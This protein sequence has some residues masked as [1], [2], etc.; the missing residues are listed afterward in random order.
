MIVPASPIPMPASIGLRLM[1]SSPT[2]AK[3]RVNAS[4]CAPATTDQIISLTARLAAL[5]T[6][7]I[8]GLGV[9]AGR[10]DVIP[11]GALIADRVARRVGRPMLVSESDILDGIALSLLPD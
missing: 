3:T 5:T 8:R 4:L 6:E 9:P 1:N 11:A 10:A 2:I 7:E